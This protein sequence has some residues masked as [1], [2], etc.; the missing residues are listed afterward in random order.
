MVVVVN[1]NDDDDD[2]DDNNNS[3]DDDDDDDDNNIDKNINILNILF[4]VD[5]L[6]S[7]INLDVYQL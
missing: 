6:D 7:M 1:C 4:I 2:D 5:E 3:N